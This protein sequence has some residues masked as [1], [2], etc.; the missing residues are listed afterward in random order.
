MLE[1]QCSN[2]SVSLAG[3]LT[4]LPEPRAGNVFAVYEKS[5]ASIL[6]YLKY[7]TTLKLL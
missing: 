5:E 6:E 2:F 1:L 4:V 7:S 3:L